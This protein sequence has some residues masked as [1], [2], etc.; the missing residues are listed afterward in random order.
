MGPNL[1]PDIHRAKLTAQGAAQETALRSDD[2]TTHQ[3]ESSYDDDK[4]S[5][6]SSSEESAGDDHESG[7]T[8]RND[9]GDSSSRA[10]TTSSEE[11]TEGNQL[12]S[13]PP[14]RPTT[15]QAVRRGSPTV[16]KPPLKIQELTQDSKLPPPRPEG[17]LEYHVA[18]QGVSPKWKLGYF[19]LE[20]G[21]RQA[22]GGKKSTVVQASM[23]DQGSLVCYRD[24][25]TCRDQD[26]MILEHRLTGLR[27]V[28]AERMHPPLKDRLTALKSQRGA[29]WCSDWFKALLSSGKV[30]T[31]GQIRRADFAEIVTAHGIRMGSRKKVSESV[32][33]LMREVSTGDDDARPIQVYDPFRF[34]CWTRGE[35]GKQVG[36]RLRCGH[37][38]VAEA[39]ARTLRQWQYY[40]LCDVTDP[41]AP[42]PRWSTTDVHKACSFVYAENAADIQRL[43]RLCEGS[44]AT[45]RAK[46]KKLDGVQ[47]R[48]LVDSSGGGHIQH[49]L[50]NLLRE[51][52]PP[53]GTDEKARARDT[54]AILM[55]VRS[56]FAAASQPH[57]DS[58]VFVAPPIELQ[59]H[60]PVTNS[61]DRKGSEVRY[62]L[63]ATLSAQAQVGVAWSWQSLRSWDATVIGVLS[64]QCE[65]DS[66]LR[67]LLKAAPTFPPTK[68]GLTTKTTPDAR[69]GGLEAYF[70]EMGDW[71]TDLRK[72]HGF[73]LHGI[74]HVAAFLLPTAGHT[75]A[76][77]EVKR[78]ALAWYK[79]HV[80]EEVRPPYG[81]PVDPKIA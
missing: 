61:R 4:E 53:T 13:S 79:Q 73:A 37:A 45:G 19:A 40:H 42:A 21:V 54:A 80:H 32:E 55:F 27:V 60:G 63:A 68:S 77:H 18:S 15:P 30:N 51:L 46:L 14:P 39:W 64:E 29:P 17:W 5:T 10:S 33:S 41:A 65:K 72:Q 38:A 76:E 70:E 56:L 8:S 28:Y 35:D 6:D 69:K 22:K 78:H 26:P 59:V 50:N 66:S 25:E 47:L 23:A 9:S 24:L 67:E 58:N 2:T 62:I 11:R 36:I 16:P 12:P 52:A 3:A 57:V 20:T 43:L 44:R 81:N 7:S 49:H 31:S 48:K 34:E 75:I 1:P 74:H 71:A